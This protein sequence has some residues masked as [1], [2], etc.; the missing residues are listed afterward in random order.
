MFCVLFHLLFYYSNYYFL[1]YYSYYYTFLLSLFFILFVC[2]FLGNRILVTKWTHKC[3]EDPRSYIWISYIHNF[4]VN[5]DNLHLFSFM[6]KY[7]KL[8]SLR[9]RQAAGTRRGGCIRRLKINLP[10]VKYLA[11]LTVS[12]YG[13]LSNWLMIK[14]VCLSNRFLIG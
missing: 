13:V 2:F 10:P 1:F 3:K 11:F 8:I 12:W 4:K 14:E 6:S 7:G 9:I 5:T